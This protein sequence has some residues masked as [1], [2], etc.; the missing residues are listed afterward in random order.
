[1]IEPRLLTRTQ[2]RGYLGGIS[3]TELDRRMTSGRLPG[4]LWGVAAADK[5]ARWDRRAVDHALDCASAIPGSVEADVQ[6]LD[7]GLGLS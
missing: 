1:M 4:P 3:L 6:I 2:L 5:A 7:R